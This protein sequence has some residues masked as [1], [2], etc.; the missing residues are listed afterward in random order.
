[1]IKNSID[2]TL[3]KK[4]MD[5][6]YDKINKEY[7]L[8][9]QKYNNKDKKSNTNIESKEIKKKREKAV[10]F[11]IKNKSFLEEH[12]ASKEYVKKYVEKQYQE[13]NEYYDI[14]NFNSTNSN[15]EIDN[16]QVDFID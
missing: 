4:F 5:E 16:N 15:S 13:I 3:I 11:L 10:E 9:I 14:S 8:K 12:G 7:E 6:E 2:S 1:M